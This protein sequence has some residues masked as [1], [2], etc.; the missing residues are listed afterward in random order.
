MQAV[1]GQSLTA[2]LVAPPG[3]TALGAR[4]ERPV[5]R[6]IVAYWRPATLIDTTWT[7]TLDGPPDPG[8]YLLAWRSP[9]PEPP[10]Y[11]TFVP[12]CATTG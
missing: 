1:A 4:L 9:D 12:V 6:E 7:V 2:T 11:E 8:E 3:V 10:A 5:T